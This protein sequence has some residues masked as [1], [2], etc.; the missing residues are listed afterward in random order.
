MTKNPDKLFVHW[1]E[2]SSGN[3]TCHRNV[4]GLSFHES[5][6]GAIVGTP[7]KYFYIISGSTEEFGP[8]DDLAKVQRALMIAVGGSILNSWD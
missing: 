6:L 2:D 3:R 8:F 1:W 7:G 4:L 5:Y